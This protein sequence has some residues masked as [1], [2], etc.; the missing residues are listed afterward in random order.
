[1]KIAKEKTASTLNDDND[2]DS[3]AQWHIKYPTRFKKYT[4]ALIKSS[5]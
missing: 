3:V 2:D 5:K 4:E 1:M